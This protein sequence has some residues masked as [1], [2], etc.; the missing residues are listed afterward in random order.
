MGQRCRDGQNN[1]VD[2]QLKGLTISLE[3]EVPNTVHLEKRV[4]R[5]E[6]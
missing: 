3:N 6:T 2:E 1:R 5:E 4:P